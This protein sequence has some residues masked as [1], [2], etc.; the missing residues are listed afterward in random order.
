[1]RFNI[2]NSLR[3]SL[4]F[5]LTE[6]I[7]SIKYDPIFMLHINYFCLQN[8]E[9]QK[10]KHDFYEARKNKMIGKY[11]LF[12]KQIKRFFF[13]GYFPSGNYVKLRVS[14]YIMFCH[15]RPLLLLVFFLSNHLQT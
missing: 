3:F 14:H 7:D 12:L 5:N 2:F 8:G 1:M 11:L 4:T 15:L 13:F 10:R 9:K 6:I